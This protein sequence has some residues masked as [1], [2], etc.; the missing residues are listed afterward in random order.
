M[1]PSLAVQ[2]TY[3][4]ETNLLLENKGCFCLK[5]NTFFASQTQMLLS[6]RML[7]SL[8]TMKTMLTRFQYCALKMFPSKSNQT[9]MADGG[10]KVGEKR[11]KERNW[12]DEERELLIA[13]YDCC[14][15]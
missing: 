9:A 4:K 3:V 1:F 5:S 2:E 12:K 15:M 11:K 7:P 14:A 10:V 6:K 13:L 8:A